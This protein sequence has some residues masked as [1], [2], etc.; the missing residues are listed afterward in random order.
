ME[1]NIII[2]SPVFN[3]DLKRMTLKQTE[4]FL[5]YFGKRAIDELKAKLKGQR[6]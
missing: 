4:N 6:P 3:S 2:Y 5:K 1:H